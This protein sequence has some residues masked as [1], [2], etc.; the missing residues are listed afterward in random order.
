M[1]SK[2]NRKVI[3]QRAGQAV[4]KYALRRLSVG[5]ASVLLGT[6]VLL[7]GSQ[8]IGHA[9]TQADEGQNAQ[10][11]MTNQPN[12]VTAKET[13]QR[14]NQATL[15]QSAAQA[16]KQTQQTSGASALPANE[17]STTPA[18]AKQDVD[19]ANWQYQA[20]ADGLQLTGYTGTTPNIVIPNNVDFELA[21]KLNQGQTVQITKDVIASLL[22]TNPTTLA[23]STTGDG[24]IIAAGSDWSNAFGGSIIYNGNL[25]MPDKLTSLDLTGLDTS[26]ITNMS[27]MFSGHRQQA[28]QTI[29]GLDRWDVSHVTNMARMFNG[30][31]NLQSVGDLSHWDVAQVTDMSFMFDGTAMQSVGDLTNWQVGNVTDMQRMFADTKLQSVGLLDQWQ[32]HNV[33]NMSGMFE[34]TA[35]RK[36]DLT[37]WDV[38]QVRDLSHLF[39]SSALTQIGSLDRW[40]VS[41]A[42]TMEFMFNATKFTD[43]GNLDQWQVG[44]VTNMGGMFGGSDLT[45]VGKLAN[46]DVHNVTTMYSMFNGCS[47]KKLDLSKWDV[48]N[49]TSMTNMFHNSALTDLGDLSN[50]QVGNVT[51]FSSMFDESKVSTL[52]ISN[53]DFAKAVR[54]TAPFQGVSKMFANNRVP[55]VI[56]ANHLQNVP[57]T[58]EI[59]DFNAQHQRDSSKLVVIT[60]NDTLLNLKDRQIPNELT[61]QDQQQE[62]TETAPTFYQSN[63]SNDAHAIVLKQVQAQAAAFLTNHPEYNGYTIVNQDTATPVELANATIQLTKAP[64]KVQVVGYDDVTKQAITGTSLDSDDQQLDG[65]IRQLINDLKARYYVFTN[66]VTVGHADGEDY[67]FELLMVASDG[68]AQVPT[69]YVH[70]NHGTQSTAETKTVRQTIHYV[71]ADGTTAAPDQVKPV[72]FTRTNTVD[73][74]TG[75]TTHGAWSNDGSYTFAPVTSPAI[76]GYTP[77]QGEVASQVVTP[78]SADLVTTVVYAKDQPVT[79]GQPDDQP[80][81]GGHEQPQTPV[82]HQPQAGQAQPK[83]VPTMATAQQPAAKKTAHQQ[84]P[85]TGNDHGEALTAL[86]LVAFTSMLG[87]GRKK[88]D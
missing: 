61:Y 42:T 15:Q 70:F 12:E 63:G 85:Q 66:Q 4:P 68:Q 47:L 33:Q 8:Q 49:V 31:D 74:V 48:A 77:S 6:T 88:R 55:K 29:T 41:K 62:V 18:Q 23:V 26:Q 30:D 73:L 82:N 51:N 10:E 13:N 28:L 45:N 43:I 86:T 58:F 57:S 72:T 17:P 20:T 25:V 3:R 32:V 11:V 2:S 56:I 46:W 79:P 35:L 53:W 81:P 38:S 24:K 34:G 7:A 60:D 54:T 80:V 19:V 39:A 75:K 22:A 84:L 64:Q 59:A 67:P 27:G 9:D 5:V 44:N 69:Y 87:L 76:P 65:S 14:S 16:P 83:A 37:N 1:V 52:N 71:F 78:A 40:D 36:L 50:W 21:G